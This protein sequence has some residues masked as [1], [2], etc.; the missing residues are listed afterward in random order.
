MRREQPTP[1]KKSVV[2]D[3]IERVGEDCCDGVADV[4]ADAVKTLDRRYDSIPTTSSTNN[5]EEVDCCGAEVRM[6]FRNCRK[7]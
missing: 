3:A 7:R 6:R 1:R 5:D 4:V 2:G